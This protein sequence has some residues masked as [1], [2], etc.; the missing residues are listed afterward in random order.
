[1]RLTITCLVLSAVAFAAVP[2][3]ER[4][5]TGLPP[6]AVA[7]SLPVS[8]PLPVVSAPRQE[9]GPPATLAQP[10]TI[11]LLATPNDAILLARTDAKQLPFSERPFVRYV[12]IEQPTV[13]RG[14]VAALTLNWISRASVPIQPPAIGVLGKLLLVRV[15]LRAFAPRQGDLEDWL[16]IWEELQFDPAFSLLITKDTLD[17]LDFS[18]LQDGGPKVTRKRPRR[19]G[20]QGFVEEEVTL[21]T[22]K[23]EGVDL[24]RDIG[25]H[26]DRTA[27]RDLSALLGETAAPIV[28][29]GYFTQRALTTIQGAGLFKRLYSGLYYQF[30]GIRKADPKKDGKA[31]DFDVML[32][33][34]GITED[35]A[36]LFDRL[37]S[38]LRVAVFRSKV[39]GDTRVVELY[40]QLGQMQGVLAVTRDP[41]SQNVDVG[42]HPVMNL[43]RAKFKASEVI[44]TRANG[45]QYFALYNA[46]GELQ[47]E[48]P[49]D[50]AADRSI[51]SPHPT[52]LQP[53]ISCIRCHGSNLDGWQPL[54]NDVRDLV[55]KYKPDVFGDATNVRQEIADTL[56]HLRAQYAGQ[57]PETVTLPR[58]RDDYA[59]AVFKAAGSWKGKNPAESV[60]LG[61][62]ATADV[63]KLYAYDLVTPLVACRELGVDPGRRDPVQVLRELLPPAGGPI[64]GVIPEDPRLAGLLAGIPIGRNDW[65]LSFT[66][67]AAR[68][69]ATL[70]ARPRDGG[71]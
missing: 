40:P 26:I 29:L 60:K 57:D 22:L 2:L 15:H 68:A 54:R 12:W 1:M 13:E 70:A 50:I 39:T 52:Q 38:D 49:P 64:A 24:V 71:K 35:L 34:I 53:A 61:S 25:L 19:D 16:R 42:A 51:P 30:S 66:F 17:A 67:A 58:A 45:M 47:D 18:R 48:V 5:T 31:T 36:K 10:D 21:V 8:P 44:F 20:K 55:A 46:A 65:N 43:V 9:M 27:W 7:Q 59:R 32:R 23:K 6:D 69:R 28:S 4:P 56:D 11:R 37:R 62:E 14:K 63:Y 41:G 33:S 3:P